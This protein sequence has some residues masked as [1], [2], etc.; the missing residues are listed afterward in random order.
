MD[1]TPAKKPSTPP[2]RSR[3]GG[4]FDRVFTRLGGEDFVVE[5]AKDNPTQFMQMMVALNP[6]PRAESKD[7]GPRISLNIHPS[8]QPGPLDKVVSEQ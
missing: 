4:M 2:E 7:S 6:P 8:L 5:W 3:M 1:N